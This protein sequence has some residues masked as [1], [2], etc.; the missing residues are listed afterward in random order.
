[1]PASAALYAGATVRPTGA[2]ETAAL[3]AGKALTHQADP[4]VR[5]LAALQTPG[6]P[7]LSFAARRR[8]LAGAARGRLPDL[9]ELRQRA[10]VAARAGPAR[11][12][13]Q[14]P[15]PVRRQRRPGRARARHERRG[16]ARSF[17]AAQAKHAG[18]HATSYR[19]VAYEVDAAGVAFGLVDRFAV[20]GSESGLRSVIDTARG[21]APLQQPSDYAKLLAT[22]PAEAL[23][24][25]YSNP[26]AP[27]SAAPRRARKALAGCSRCSPARTRRTSRSFASAGS[28]A[29]DADTLTAG[30]GGGAGG[31]LAATRKPRRRSANCRAN[32][33]SRSA[34]AIVAS[35][36]R[37][38]RAGPRRA[39]PR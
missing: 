28:L 23:A 2:R 25:V 16:K 5:L 39:R 32:R 35:D 9:A 18:A 22:A 20:I 31:L 4:Y 38:R 36:A 37:R 13:E 17:L 8:A 19:G 14:R 12:L 1:M 30:A 26:R 7:P 27:P 3:A 34:S 6:S 29:L 11:R 15:L 21:G 24:H 10:A 33:G